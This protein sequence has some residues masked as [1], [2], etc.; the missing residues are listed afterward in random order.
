VSQTIGKWGHS[1]ALRI[2]RAFA[3]QLNWD[4]HTQVEPKIVDGKLVIQAVDAGDIPYYSLE[5]L[6]VGLTPDTAHAEID[7]GPAVGKEVW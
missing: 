2:P 6:L 7:T 5:E 4:E 1:L 3:E